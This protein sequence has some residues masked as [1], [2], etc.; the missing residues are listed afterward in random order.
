MANTSALR[1]PF[2]RAVAIDLSVFSNQV[3]LGIAGN[4]SR[5][6]SR[7]LGGIGVHGDNLYERRVQQVVDTGLIHRFAKDSAGNCGDFL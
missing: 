7:I 6:E 4:V 1:V 3:F 5:D 2:L